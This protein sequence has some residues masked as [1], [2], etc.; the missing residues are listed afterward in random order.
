MH[1][2]S[3][4]DSGELMDCKKIVDWLG[5][6]DNLP[7]EPN[8]S[9]LPDDKKVLNGSLRALANG[10]GLSLPSSS[11]CELELKPLILLTGLLE[12]A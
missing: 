3:V 4:Y 10:S 8:R 7:A 2:C 5:K 6:D 11:K 1:N 9:P 12:P